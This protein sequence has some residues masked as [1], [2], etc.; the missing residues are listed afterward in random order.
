MTEPVL[1]ASAVSWTTEG[2]VFVVRM[3]NPP[4]NQ[5]GQPL[6]D[7]LAGAGGA[8]EDSPARVLVICSAL[9][10]FF[11]AGCSAAI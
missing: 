7:G 4:A 1:S 10:R 5:L 9:D 2:P 11:A 6:V 8:F 3:D